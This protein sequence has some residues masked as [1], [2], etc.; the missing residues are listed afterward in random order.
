MVTTGIRLSILLEMDFLE[1]WW[2]ARRRTTRIGCAV[3][4]GFSPLVPS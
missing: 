3:L 4:H 2:V 1:K